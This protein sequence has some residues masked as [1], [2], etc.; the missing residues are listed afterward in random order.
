MESRSLNVPRAASELGLCRTPEAQV[1]GSQAVAMSKPERQRGTGRGAGCGRVPGAAGLPAL[2][3]EA[4]PALTGDKRKERVP[5]P[6]RYERGGEC[7]QRRGEGH[8]SGPHSRA[9]HCFCDQVPCSIVGVLCV[10]THF[11]TMPGLWWRTELC[12]PDFRL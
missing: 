6:H 12:S 11:F 7:P 3:G 8:R 9:P 1:G 4:C 5:H 2:Q 10:S